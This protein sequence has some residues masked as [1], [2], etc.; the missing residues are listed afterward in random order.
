MFKILKPKQQAQT[1]GE[2]VIVIALIVGVAT[3][4]SMMVRRGL[5]ARLNDTNTYMMSTVNAA[6]VASRWSNETTPSQIARE[7]EPYYANT[8]SSVRRDVNDT[9][10]LLPGGKKTGIF[11]ALYNET[12]S[13]NT[14]SEQAPPGSAY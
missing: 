14:V 1:I 7:Y 13:A 3:A 12:T 5:Q 11:R 6:Y 4:M 2:Y 9:F 8:E 10:S